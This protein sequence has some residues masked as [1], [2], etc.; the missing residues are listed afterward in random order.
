MGYTGAKKGSWL[1]YPF[2]DRKKEVAGAPPR[3]ASPVPCRRAPDDDE[4]PRPT[5]IS[6]RRRGN[7]ASVSWLAGRKKAV[8]DAL[9]RAASPVPR[10]RAPEDDEGPLPR[11]SPPAAAATPTAFLGSRAA[12]KRPA[13]LRLAL[14]RPYPGGAQPSMTKPPRIPRSS[15]P[16]AAPARAS[17]RALKL[18][19]PLSIG[20]GGAP[21]WYAFRRK[22]LYLT[23]ALDLGEDG[24]AAGEDDDDG[25]PLETG[26][27][28]HEKSIRL[29]GLEDGFL[30][31]VFFVAG[32]GL[33]LTTGFIAG[34]SSQT[35]RVSGILMGCA[36]L[37]K[38]PGFI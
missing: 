16:A 19:A 21:T 31:P 38:F 25:A 15:P 24:G 36:K 5:S 12:R 1:A 8:G 28:G 20:F 22:N 11:A 13:A 27:V 29:R 30:D 10:R 6:S 9:P 35:L 4:G 32:P 18:L 7:A 34:S 33:F 37:Q 3:A 17:E 23:C 14:P 26:G 2:V